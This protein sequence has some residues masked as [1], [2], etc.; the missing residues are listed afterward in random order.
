[1]ASP[2]RIPIAVL[3]F[4]WLLAPGIAGLVFSNACVVAAVALCASFFL[5]LQKDGWPD[6]LCLTILLFVA[7]IPVNVVLFFAGCVVIMNFHR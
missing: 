7:A 6:R 5:A 4:F 2:P 3:W 1:M